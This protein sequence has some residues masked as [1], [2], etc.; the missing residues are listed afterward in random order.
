MVWNLCKGK[1]ICEVGEA[2]TASD[3]LD[4]TKAAR[5]HIGHGGCGHKQPVVRKEGL[6]L[7]ANFKSGQSDDNSNEG[8]LYI[9]PEKVLSIFKR[10]SDE[11]CI[12]MGLNSVNSRPEWMILTVLPVP[13]PPVR[14][15]IL[16]D[17]MRSEDDL[18]YKL[19]DILKANQ[20]LIKHEQ[21]GSP[22]HVLVEYEQLL[23][24]HVATYMDN[25][26]P[27]MPQALQKSG[28]PLKSIKARLKGKEGRIRGNRSLSPRRSSLW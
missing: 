20:N 10:I 13:P 28:R 9:S 8:K 2:P 25:D 17:S 12:A 7:V 15:S 19:G 22:A 11:D 5:S 27:G 1:G 23:Q 14:P 4:T 3:A 16:M 21:D 18:T 6:R 26:L 24:F